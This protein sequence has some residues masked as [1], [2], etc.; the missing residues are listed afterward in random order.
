MKKSDDTL[1]AK[2]MAETI[3]SVSY[4]SI[5]QWSVVYDIENLEL[6][7][8]FQRQFENPLEFSIKNN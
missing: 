1:S 4:P 8:Y 3:E 7:F 6:D 2:D 5:T